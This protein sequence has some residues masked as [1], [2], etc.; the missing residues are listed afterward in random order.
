M[1]SG[2]KKSTPEERAQAKEMWLSGALS[3]PHI[4]EKFGRTQA[5]IYA[6][7]KK[8]GWSP[9]SPVPASRSTQMNDRI[10]ER[11]A[12]EAARDGAIFGPLLPDVIF[13][14]QRDFAVTTEGKKFV[15]DG[16]ALDRE[17][18]R[19][20]V[21]RERRLSQPS[22]APAA[23]HNNGRRTLPRQAVI[24]RAAPASTESTGRI[25]TNSAQ[26]GQAGTAPPKPD[27]PPSI[28]ARVDAIEKRVEELFA[29]VRD[30]IKGRRDAL[31]DQLDGLDAIAA[32]L[33]PRN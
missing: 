16:K 3:A 15:V 17:D 19:A 7:A 30:A 21:D 26:S 32:Q 20:L 11:R 24:Q 9:R 13:L 5:W 10:K 12:E 14:R 22:L 27:Q 1:T 31:S 33:S 4:A 29:T 8:E 6:L 25:R 18:F 2:W 23:G 28:V